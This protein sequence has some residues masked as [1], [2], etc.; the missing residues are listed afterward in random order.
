MIW[1][2]LSV[3]GII[4]WTRLTYKLHYNLNEIG[5]QN[6]KLKPCIFYGEIDNVKLIIVVYAGLLLFSKSLDAIIRIKTILNQSFR[7]K[8]LGSVSEILGLKI[9]RNPYAN[10]IKILQKNM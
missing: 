9:E 2:N 5:L 4:S 3:N 7:M 1:T 10:I 8:D 6:S